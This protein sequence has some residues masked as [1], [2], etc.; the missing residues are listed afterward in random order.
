[1]RIQKITES[2]QTLTEAVELG[3]EVRLG[4][5]DDPLVSGGKVYLFAGDKVAQKLIVTVLEP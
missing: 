2:G 3:T 1:M 4:R 5:R